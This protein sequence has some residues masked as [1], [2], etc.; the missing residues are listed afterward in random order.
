MTI[1]L[2]VTA[3]TQAHTPQGNSKH[4]VRFKI[5]VGSNSKIIWE[6]K[7]TALGNVSY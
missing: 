2:G 1:I 4:N 6:L 7:I 3:I 5:A